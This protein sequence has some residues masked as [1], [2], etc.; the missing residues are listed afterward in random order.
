[1]TRKFKLL[2]EIPELN[3]LKVGD[4]KE[5]DTLYVEYPARCEFGHIVK[6]K[7]IKYDPATRPDLWEEIK[8]EKI[9][10]KILALTGLIKNEEVFDMELDE[11]MERREWTSRENP[12]EI[13]DVIDKA[14]GDKNTTI[15][16]SK[17]DLKRM[18][19]REGKKYKEVLGILIH[20][21]ATGE[22][23]I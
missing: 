18:E 11:E 14:T 12:K 13:I 7:N 23:K 20:K 19:Q 2:K 4:I 3:T 15:E 6:N 10:P 21:F 22:I 9:N 1:M 16:I 5:I 17:E 8:E